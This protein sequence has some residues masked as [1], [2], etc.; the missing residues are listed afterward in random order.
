MKKVLIA[1][2]G[3]AV[4]ALVAAAVLFLNLEG[5]VDSAVAPDDQEEVVF[6]V[7]KGTSA[8]GIGHKLEKEGFIKNARV[9]RFFLFR[10]GKL[11]AKAGRHALKKSMTMRQIGE[12]LEGNPM[13]EDVPFT[14][15][16]GWRLRDS[17]AALAEKGW[18]KKGQY[19][20]LAKDPSQF[21]APFSLPGS[22]LEGYLYP[23]TYGVI[24]PT[25]EGTIDV[26]ALL[27][28]QVDAFV[29]KFYEPNKGAIEKSGRT[30]HDLVKM[31]SMLEREEPV[32]A[33]RP[34]V[35]G[36][37]WKR[38]D[39][40]FPL[41]VDATSRYE[42]E[43]WNDRSAFLKRLRDKSDAYNT[44]HKKG[45]P[46]TPIG[47]PTLDSLKA[48]MNPKKSEFLYYLHDANKVLHPSRNAAEHEA[49]RKKYNVY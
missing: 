34:L 3:L 32:P 13:P 2:V 8:R 20:D 18:I 47:A 37:L 49:L 23:E 24:P 4:V 30:L 15:V 1:V 39:M 7:P 41:G 48:A 22:G 45:L 6:V 40:G 16:E 5:Q 35:A 44:R 9:W 43:K 11:D 12:A 27:Q 19:Q 17:D 14:F 21:K 31:A 28:R 38:I 25:G 10:R 46:P 36:I 29:D 33:Q 26:K 42:L